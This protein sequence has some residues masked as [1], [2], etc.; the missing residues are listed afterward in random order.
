MIP[1]CFIVGQTRKVSQCAQKHRA[2]AKR[3][4][5]ELPVIRAAPN[6]VIAMR[7]LPKKAEM[8][9]FLVPEDIIHSP[10]KLVI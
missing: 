7:R 1:F 10:W 2:V 9:T 3:V 8:I 6:L 4:R 5:A